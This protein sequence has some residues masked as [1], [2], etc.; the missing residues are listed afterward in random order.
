M[1][2][3]VIAG[4]RDGD[5]LVGAGLGDLLCLGGSKA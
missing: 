2:L 4:D 5:Y 3:F 1:S